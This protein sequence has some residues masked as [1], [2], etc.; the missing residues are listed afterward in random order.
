MIDHVTFIIRKYRLWQPS[1]S[2]E[3]VHSSVEMVTLAYTITIQFDM[4]IQR[5]S[6]G[7]S[8]FR[9]SSTHFPLYAKPTLP[10]V[11]FE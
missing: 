9:E 6:N 10:I 2:V 8:K 3:L 4:F 1:K 7:T 11:L 5:F